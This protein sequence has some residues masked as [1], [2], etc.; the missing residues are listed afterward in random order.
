MQDP[1]ALQCTAGGVIRAAPLW[2]HGRFTVVLPYVTAACTSGTAQFNSDT[3]SPE[4]GEGRDSPNWQQVWCTRPS[5]V[6]NP[7]LHVM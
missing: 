3:A 5:T 6:R 2:G 7:V 4:C 1:A